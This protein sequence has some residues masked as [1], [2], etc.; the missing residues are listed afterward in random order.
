MMVQDQR[1]SSGEGTFETTSMASVKTSS[2]PENVLN[3][4]NCF[5]LGMVF[6]FF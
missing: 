4:P 2:P 5:V 6:F 1:E 3:Q